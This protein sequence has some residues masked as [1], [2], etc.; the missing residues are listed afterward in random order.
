MSIG[1][2]YD[3]IIMI[4]FAIYAIYLA[5]T[6]KEKLGNKAKLLMVCGVIMIVL[7]IIMILTSLFK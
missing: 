5:K 4:G 1:E 2:F 7:A 3:K 6:K